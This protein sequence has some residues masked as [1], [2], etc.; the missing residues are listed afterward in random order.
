MSSGEIDGMPM[1][2]LTTPMM[3][4]AVPRAKSAEMIGRMAAKTEPNTRSRTT[5]ASRTPRPVLLKDGLLA[6]SASCPVTATVRP[7]PDVLV[8][9]WTNFF[10]SAPEML[11][12]NLSKVTWRNPTVLSALM[13][14]VLTRLPD[15]S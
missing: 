15:A 8:T 12:A 14:D 1:A 3:P 10:D 11:L 9:S 6:C 5:R 2:W 7:S 4:T 13:F